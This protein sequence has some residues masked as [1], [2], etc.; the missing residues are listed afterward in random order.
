[1]SELV[2]VRVSQ[3]ERKYLQKNGLLPPGLLRIVSEAEPLPHG[4]YLLRCPRRDVEGIRDR[5]TECLARTGFDGAYN[6]TD[7]GR[8]LEDL[9]DTLFIP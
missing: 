2:E 4:A 1:M 8:M 3:M 7:D 9:I 5:L 6:L